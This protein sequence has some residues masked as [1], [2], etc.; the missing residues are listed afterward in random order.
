ILFRD[1]RVAALGERLL[2]ASVQ[3]SIDRGRVVEPP[4]STSRNRLQTTTLLDAIAEHKFDCAFGGARRDE[5][6]ARAK[7]RVF[8][9][10]DEFGQWN[11]KAQRPELW[12]LYNARIHPGEHVRIFPLSNWTE[13][14]V[15]Q[16]VAGAGIGYRASPPVDGR[17]G[18]RRQVDPDRAI[19]LRVEGDLRGPARGDRAGKSRPGARPAQP[20]AADRRPA[21]RARA[22]HHDRR[23]LPLLLD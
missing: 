3:D 15:W 21:R 17:V 5:E 6:K 23:R 14:D 12:S 13:L 8:S 2:V 19:A 18:R 9:F 11:P 7:E 16:Y 1:Q 20:G 4:G 22:G 10:R